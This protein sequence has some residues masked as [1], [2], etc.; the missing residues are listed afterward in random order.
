MDDEEPVRMTVKEMLTYLGYEV[1]TSADGEEAI[2][3][4]K[5]SMEEGSPY[6]AV[7]LDLTIP[8]GMGGKET[9]KRLKEIAPDVNAIVSSGYSIDPIMAEYDKYDFSGVIIKPYRIS[10]I[11]EVLKKTLSGR[12]DY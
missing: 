12:K 2:A 1:D 8:G 9:A 6:D 3:M 5:T 11:A 10:D 4:Y 7:I